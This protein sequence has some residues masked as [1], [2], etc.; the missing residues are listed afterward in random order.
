M[1]GE[2]LFKNGKNHLDLYLN[3][4]CNLRCNHCFVGEKLEKRVE[5]EIS[6]VRKIL[7]YSRSC[8]ATSVSL[9]GGERTI[10]PFINEVIM[11]C[12]DL[13]YPEIKLVTNGMKP[14]RKISQ[15][16]SR[17]NKPT[18]VFS[19]DSCEPE[20]FERIRG[21]NTFSQLEKNIFYMLDKGYECGAILS[22]SKTNYKSVINTIQYLNSYNFAYVNIHYVN[23]IGFAT[24]LDLVKIEDWFL[25][26]KE[27][28]KISQQVNIRIKFE[29][30]FKSASI[31]KTSKCVL[32]NNVEGNVMIFPDNKVYRCALFLDY[33]NL[34]SLYWN[35]SEIVPNEIL[36]T[37]QTIASKS[38]NGCPMSSSILGNDTDYVLTCMYDKTCF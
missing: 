23:S 17:Y 14:V 2:A 15:I 12:S 16:D 22:V 34:N 27:I 7:E 1:I 18:I 32:K 33:G 37:E 5:F 4:H 6:E 25:I 20:I 36:T 38:C 29:D 31:S 10:Y 3:Y 8:G 28:E 24:D 13:G 11:Y 9:L 21:R 35:G 30:K 19:V 26:K